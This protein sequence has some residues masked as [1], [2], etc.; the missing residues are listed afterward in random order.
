[1]PS[2]RF[3]KCVI[4]AVL[5]A[6]LIFFQGGLSAAPLE[7]GFASAP[8]ASAT[9]EEKAAAFREARFRV[10]VDACKYERTPYRQGGVSKSGFDCS[11]F[12]YLSFYDALGVSVPR[13]SESLF[14]WAEE[15]SIEE[16]LPGDLLFFRTTSAGNISHV[17]IYLGSGRF[18]HAASE[19]SRTGV[20]YSNLNESYWTRTYAGAGRALPVANMDIKTEKIN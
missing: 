6:M 13:Y 11:G 5:F 15:I 14:Q 9:P 8:R 4:A 16:A 19:G 2:F 17:G 7:G 3:E 1:M 12:V 10:I 18:I 20:I